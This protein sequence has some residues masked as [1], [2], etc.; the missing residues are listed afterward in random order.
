M[1]HKL[2][3]R[4]KGPLKRFLKRR[5]AAAARI[6]EARRIAVA[7]AQRAGIEDDH[8]GQRVAAEAVKRVVLD[9]V[10]RPA[11]EKTEP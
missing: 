2:G 1:S 10:G 9:H 7:L 11:A 8:E 6:R 5:A 3:K 4:G